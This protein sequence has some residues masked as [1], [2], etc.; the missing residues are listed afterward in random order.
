[1]DLINFIDYT[2]KGTRFI[3]R[4]AIE[5]IVAQIIRVIDAKKDN[6]LR[7]C[8]GAVIANE[9]KIIWMKAI[10]H[11]HLPSFQLKLINKFN[12]MLEDV[13]ADNELH[14]I[15][16][17]SESLQDR[18]LFMHNME[19]NHYGKVLFWTEIDKNIE[20]F[21]KKKASLKPL[22]RLVSS[23]AKGDGDN[24]NLP[25]RDNAAQPQSE[26]RRTDRQEDINPITIP[27]R[28]YSNAVDAYNTSENG[29]RGNTSY[30]R[31]PWNRF[32][33]SRRYNRRPWHRF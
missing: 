20:K 21:E 19:L 9:P 25:R 14:H 5:W 33:N 11:V 23:K 17:I 2:K 31:R 10:R 18:N 24:Q 28:H 3:F 27:P 15:M 30:R 4:E 13:L 12:N 29:F 8:A 1:M 22:H 16:D 6:L 26:A 7:R 32:S